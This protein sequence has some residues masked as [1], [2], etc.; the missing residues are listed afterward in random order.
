MNIR[1]G[2][3]RLRPAH[4][5]PGRVIEEY[6]V[7]DSGRGRSSCP[8]PCTHHAGVQLD[9]ASIQIAASQSLAGVSVNPTANT[10]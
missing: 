10:P 2:G 3:R 8:S 4:E 5:D 9:G 7:R 6:A 1:H